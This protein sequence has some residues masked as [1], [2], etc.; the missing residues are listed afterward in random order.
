MG[1]SNW[2]GKKT[3]EIQEKIQ[4]YIVILSKNSESL[5]P[6]LFFP[7]LFILLPVG[8]EHPYHVLV[9]LGNHNFISVFLKVFYIL[10]S[11]LIF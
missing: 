6:T 5:K 9:F 2:I 10:F 3:A 7:L 11:Y 1:L 4:E 8:F